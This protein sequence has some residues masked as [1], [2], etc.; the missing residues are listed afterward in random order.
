MSARS[1]FT[2]VPS[3]QADGPMATPGGAGITHSPLPTPAGN[4]AQIH[5][6]TTPT[7]SKPG[8]AL[9]GMQKLPAPKPLSLPKTMKAGVYKALS[10][11][12]EGASDELA[13]VLEAEN[14][15]QPDAHHLAVAHVDPS[16][17]PVPP[18]APAVAPVTPL[19]PVAHHPKIAMRIPTNA[20]IE[21]HLLAAAVHGPAAVVAAVQQKIAGLQLT[22]GERE[23]VLSMLQDEEAKAAAY[24]FTQ[25]SNGGLATLSKVIALGTALAGPAAAGVQMLRSRMEMDKNWAGVQQAAPD[26]IAKDPV[27]ARAL[28]ELIHKTAPAVA[29]N[30]VV[31]GDL[32]RQMTAMPIVDLGSVDR[33]ANVGKSTGQGSSVASP[34][35]ML[36]DA[37]E[38]YNT[39]R[40]TWDKAFGAK[41]SHLGTPATNL[42]SKGQPR[43]LDWST[44]AM[45]TAG[46]T[47][48]FVGSGTPIEQANQG[49][50][51][52]QQAAQLPM[53][54]L[55]AVVRELLAKEMELQTREEA[56]A[57]R[58]MMVAQAEQLYQGMAQA[59]GSQYG[60]DPQ[61]GQPMPGGGP[62]ATPADD[63][64]AADSMSGDP[65]SGSPATDPMDVD[66]ASG[67]PAADPAASDPAGSNP[68]G[69]APV[70]ID[71][72]AD[73]ASVASNDAA[74]ASAPPAETTEL[75][76][77]AGGPM[78]A[79]GV[80]PAGEPMPPADLPNVEGS[81]QDEADHHVGPGALPEGSPEDQAADQALAQ[82]MAQTGEDPVPAADSPP[83]STEG[84]QDAHNMGAEAAEASEAS[85]LTDPAVPADT[86]SDSTV[87]PADTGSDSAVM[88]AEPAAGPVTYAT[89]DAVSA[90]APPAGPIDGP[91]TGSAAAALPAAPPAGMGGQ[92][93]LTIPLPPL[94]ISVKMGSAR[95]SADEDLALFYAAH[96]NLFKV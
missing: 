76:A 23:A 66:P 52:S 78:D 72:A 27:R 55:D 32:L 74:S 33:L 35:A 45:K 68:V 63:A 61:S 56:V 36:T 20:E 69:G 4:P 25:P 24:S 70:G 57:Q 93:N 67:D 8:G 81:A 80:S 28:F 95:Y 59:Y 94:Q 82:Q 49:F 47:E 88:P 13:H 9:Q 92:L 12:L 16:F 64:S 17:V 85:M 43:V 87:M 75:P 73:P 31:A 90:G 1:P 40:D 83:G 50:Q 18:T 51:L 14:R 29:S 48:P 71:P 34:A 38:A 30:S 6:M 15:D 11:Y 10:N 53:L 89:P 65:T 84:G 41:V 44:P 77:D 54:P 46:I 62:A 39:S 7:E 19:L 86:G 3:E 60:V 21:T 22:A 58:E 91:D 2:A 79:G 5:S 96:A 26:V 37:G 42:D